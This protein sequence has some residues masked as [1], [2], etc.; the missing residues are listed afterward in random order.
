VLGAIALG[1]AVAGGS[2]AASRYVITK[3]ND[4]KPG[5]I[6]G[7][8]IHSH[9]LGLR[10]FSRKALKALRGKRGPVGPQGP[11]GETGAQGPTGPQGPIGATGAAGA[12]GATGAT[13]LQGPTGD[14]GPTGPQGPTGATG[15][16]GLQGPTGDWGPTG[17]Q[18]PTGATGA[19]GL[20]G[21]T[22]DTG[23]T[24]PGGPTGTY[25]ATG[26]QGPTGDWG[27]TGPQGPTG[28]TGPPG[29]PGP[30]GPTGPSGPR[31]AGGAPGPQSPDINYQVNNGSNWA[32]AN[33]PISLPNAN[34]GAGYEAANVIVDT[35]PAS[36]FNGVTYTGTGN[37]QDNIWITDGSETFTPGEHAGA[38]PL[39]FSAF[40]D[41]GDGTYT[42]LTPKATACGATVTAAQIQSCYAGYEV[43]AQVGVSGDGTTTETGHIDTVNGQPVNADVRVD[44]STAAAR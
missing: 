19:T 42:A 12:T 21:P 43:Y 31:G 9:T 11:T 27:P 35:G 4:I 22:G 24:G 41:N 7:R 3:A 6:R 5:A 39:D 32:L 33:M 17:P 36:S 8:D 15:A 40:K 26:L 29:P 1:I 20:Q 34:T 37:L 13:G 16:T 18:G 14:W 30:Q 25:G 2:W 38:D 23:P 44:S 10:V 28:A